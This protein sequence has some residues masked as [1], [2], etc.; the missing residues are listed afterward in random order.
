MRSFRH[1]TPRYIW[2][3][4]LEKAYR[5]KNP[6]LPWLTPDANLFLSTYLKPSDV[7]IEFGSGQS[8]IWFAQRIAKLVSVEH[9]RDWYERN[10]RIFEEKGI[11]N[12]EYH[13][14]ERGEETDVGNKLPPYVQV[15]EE[16]ADE[17]L[18]FALIDG[19]Y[20]DLCAVAVEKKVKPG[21]VIIIDNVNH[22][23][24]SG[25]YS[26]NSR[27]QAQGLIS[28][29]W[30]EFMSA[31]K[32]WRCIWTSNGVSDTAFYFKLRR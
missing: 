8:T 23:L 18:D 11:S 17:S 24:P 3:R 25:S 4:I 30:G 5:R 21:G 19:I 15:V 26:P 12:V 14:R 7:G 32:D 29:L 2:N 20:R 13:L 9:D 1:L 28:E 27:T 16:I 10:T 31:T 22:Y 6:E